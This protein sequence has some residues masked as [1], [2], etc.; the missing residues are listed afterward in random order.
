MAKEEKAPAISTHAISNIPSDCRQFIM[1]LEI[2]K[3]LPKDKEYKLLDVGGDTRLLA[4]FLSKNKNIKYFSLDYFG[5]HDYIH[6]LNEFPIPIA[7]SSFDIIVCLETLEHLLYP[8]KVMKELVRIAKPEA[9][10]LLS[11]P[12][13]YN[14]YCRL[15]Y[16]FGKKTAM[17]EPFKIVENH[18]HVHLPRV[19]DVNKF[20]SAHIKV[21]ETDYQWQS[22]TGGHSRGFKSKL[23]IFIDNIINSIKNIKPS[24]FARS[25][26]VYGKQKR[27]HV[28]N[29]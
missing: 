1:P 22:R 3:R 20:F 28:K 17:Q 27:R 26:I 24:I 21:L 16:L 9:I 14:F 8:H 13:E 12:N 11:M 4:K 23:F 19:R 7:S 6:D 5:K 10:F 2:I 15:N 25:I 18:R 29:G